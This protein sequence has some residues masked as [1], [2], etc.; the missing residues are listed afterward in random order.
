MSDEESTY[1]GPRPGQRDSGLFFV[2]ITM[3]NDPSECTALTMKKTT[4]SN[5]NS[6][7]NLDT[8]QKD[9]HHIQYS[10]TCFQKMTLNPSLAYSNTSS[11]TSINHSSRNNTN[12]DRLQ[13]LNN[14]ELKDQTPKYAYN[15]HPCAN[16]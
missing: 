12:S 1:T 2:P 13:F 7:T 10:S 8:D 11:N 5:A 15:T 4:L 16:N 3:K 9:F 6:I 14:M